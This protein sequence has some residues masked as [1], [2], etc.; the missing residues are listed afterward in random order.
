MPKT[1]RKI[2]VLIFLAILLLPAI[3][4]AGLRLEQTY[5]DIAG[6][7]GKSESL[8]TVVSQAASNAPTNTASLI[9]YIF[10]L[11]SVF[12]IG[13]S[14]LA[15]IIAGVQYLTSAGKVAAQKEARTRVLRSFLGL[16]I[17]IGASLILQII[18][19]GLNIPQ[20]THI[21]DSVSN[22]ILI[23]QAGIDELIKN[24]DN[25][26]KELLDKLAGDGKIKY[27]ASQSTNLE[28]NFGN[29]T[30]LSNLPNVSFREFQPNYIGF[31]GNGKDNI[32]VKAFSGTGFT[33]IGHTYSSV[34]GLQD[35]DSASGGVPE[36]GTVLGITTSGGMEITYFPLRIYP[37][38]PKNNNNIYYF[39]TE[40]VPQAQRPPLDAPSN[41]PP[42][43]ISVE[44]LSA[45]VYLYGSNDPVFPEGNQQINEDEGPFGGVGGSSGGT[46]GYYRPPPS[47]LQGN[48]PT[49]QGKSIGG[50]GGQRYIQFDVPNFADT[51]FNFDKQAISIEIKNNRQLKDKTLQDDLLV[52]LFQG[53]YYRGPFRAFFEE[54]EHLPA[55]TLYN[56]S[57]DNKNWFEDATKMVE[58][59]KNAFG[60]GGY[61]IGGNLKA[62][63]TIEDL[64]DP[65]KN[66]IK[67]NTTDEQGNIFGVS[68]ARVFHLAPVDKNSCYAVALCNGQNLQG[69][70]LVFTPNGESNNKWMSFFLPMPW[71]VPVPIPKELPKELSSE[72]LATVTEGDNMGE[73]EAFEKE[74]DFR[75]FNDSIESIGIS[76]DCVVALYDN[77]PRAPSEYWDNQTVGAKSMVF[78][79]GDMVSGAYTDEGNIPYLN[80]EKYQIHSCTSLW[81]ALKLAPP[82]SCVSSI[83]VYPIVYPIK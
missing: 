62:G 40:A 54:R 41:Y 4:L 31:F 29:L 35:N 46:G 25:I 64:N 14:T 67:I 61:G 57:L 79:R 30:K 65:A 42:L 24:A 78:S 53:A 26:N 10:T 75:I 37:V 15:V 80:L 43:S 76:G 83:A 38:D 68:S 23:S 60:S 51:S 69:Y 58:A 11:T 48:A 77:A 63:N 13:L 3:S 34:K 72:M 66:K 49:P 50:G 16:A 36:K 73:K 82:D 20:L 22:V 39:D 18:A 47:Q 32:K 19:P 8:N 44:G 5:P 28:F 45:G 21:N 71:F 70:C 17:V 27:F 56:Y 74:K 9:R 1:F 2:F 59:I 33:G 55:T 52:F 12:L 81:S 7:T 6:I